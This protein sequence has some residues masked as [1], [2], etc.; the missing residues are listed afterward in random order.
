MHAVWHS[1]C[2]LQRRGQQARVVKLTW[3]FNTSLFAVLLS[4]SSGCSSLGWFASREPQAP[5]VLGANPGTQDVVAAVNSNSRLIRQL[6]TTSASLSVPG[7]PGLAAD[8]A[9][10]RPQRLRIRARAPI[11]SQPQLDLGSNQDHFWFWVNQNPTGLAPGR[12]SP[13]YVARHQEFR[14]SAAPGVLPLEPRWIIEMLGVTTLDPAAGYQFSAG[15]EQLILRSQIASPGTPLTRQVVVHPQ[16]GWVVQQQFDDA[17]GT[18]AIAN[19]SQFRY[20]PDMGVSLPRRLQIQLLPGRQEEV[21]FQI[22]VGDYMI[23]QLIGAPSR[24]WQMPRLE[25]VPRI[26]LAAFQAPSQGAGYDPAGDDGVKPPAAALRP[27][28]RGLPQLR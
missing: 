3:L 13:V 17:T 28:Y 27:S 4:G 12:S 9:L 25:G 5:V 11:G 18:L 6:Q 22:D 15:P 2:A 19:L 14:R 20:Y 1:S 24:L 21:A 7:F 26:D 8:L 16:F 10:E 23:N